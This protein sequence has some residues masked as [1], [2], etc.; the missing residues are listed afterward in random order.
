MTTHS[1]SSANPTTLREG[2]GGFVS[3]RLLRLCSVLLFLGLFLGTVFAGLR[4]FSPEPFEEAPPANHAYALDTMQAAVDWRRVKAIQDDLVGLG[5]RF[6]GQPGVYAAEDYI[7]Q[8]FLKAGVEVYEQENWTVVP[9][10]QFREIYVADEDTQGL[11]LPLTNVEIYPFMPNHLQPVTTPDEGVVGELV[12]LTQDALRTRTSFDDCIGLIDTSEG[13]LPEEYAFDWT[14]YAQLGLKAL[15]VSHPQGLS[16]VPWHHVANENEGMVSG[17]PVNFVRVAAD[18]G[19]FDQVGRRV[20]LRVRVRFEEVPNTTLVGVLRARDSS[21]QRPNSNAVILLSSYDACSILPDRA[22]GVSQALWPATQLALLEGLAPYRTGLSRD[23]IFIA[24]GAQV[25]ARDGENNLLRLLDENIVKKERNPLKKLLG[26]GQDQ[27][28]ELQEQTHRSG[29]QARLEPW[30]KRY[31]ANAAL[32]A[33]IDEILAAFEAEPFLREAEHTLRILDDLG[34][35]TRKYVEDQVGYTLDTVVFTLT[36]SKLQAKLAFLQSGNPDPSGEPFLAYLR[37]KSECDRMVAVARYS[38]PSLL[39]GRPRTEELL[40]RYALREKCRDRFLELRAHHAKKMRQR[41]KDIKLI[42]ALNPYKR[43]IVF[44][45]CLMPAFRPER[46]DEVLSFSNG[47]WAVNAQMRSMIS[48]MAS[49]R[50]RARE[51]PGHDQI[52]TELAI[53][54]LAKLHH[55][56]V[57]LNTRPLPERSANMWTQ[58]GYLM[59]KLLSFGRSD[60]YLHFADPVDQPYM[61]DV[62]SLKHSLAV[63]GETVLSLAHGNGRFAP[64]QVGWMKKQFGGRVL[65]SGIGQSMAPNYPLKGAVLGSRPYFGWEYSWPGFYDQLLIMSDVYGRYEIVNC[66]TDFWVDHYIWANGY[67]PVAAWHGED[68]RIAWM[69]DEGE[70]GQRLYKSVNLNWFKGDVEDITLVAFR[71]APVAFLDMTNPQT[72]QDYTGL[73]LL[74][75]DGLSTLRKQCV[76]KSSGVYA[77]YIEPDT[78]FYVT[79][80]SGSVD[81]ELAKVT[82]AFML[83]PPPS[84]VVGQATEARQ[85]IDGEGYLAAEHP[86]M[87][88]MSQEVARSLAHLN[89][90]RLDLQNRHGMA[91]AQTNDYE[92]KSL[93]LLAASEEPAQPNHQATRRAR[94]AAVYGTLN[95]PV[96]RESIVE[97]LIG[98]LWYL[99]L[100]V[101]FVY[102]L[103][104]LLFCFSDIR[105]QIA[106][107]AILFPLVFVLLR[108]MHPAFEMVRSSLMILLGFIIILIAG[109]M[110]VLFFGKFKENLEDLRKKRGRVDAAEVNKFGVMGSAFM[111]GLNNMHRRKMRTWLT[112][113]TLTLI[114]FAMICFTSAN[115][116][117]AE[118]AIAI[119]KAPYQGILIKRKN[120][121]KF[122]EAELFALRTRYADRHRVCLRQMHLGVQNWEGQARPQSGTRDGVRERRP[123]PRALVQFHPAFQSTP[124]RSSIRSSSSRAPL[125]SPRRRRKPPK[126]VVPS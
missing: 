83:G 1:T 96:L 24:F 58:F 10:T 75:R 70:D 45:T 95:H 28:S 23:V 105:K 11:G 88:N 31:D 92:E 65:A 30:R 56:D 66:A 97:A 13:M 18:E 39:D 21:P 51:V 90:K 50:Q 113:A 35:E 104:K 80:E 109:G 112:C 41:D 9:Q 20:R 16:R 6:M 40:E 107:Q 98:I 122:S 8:A 68:G 2:K 7:R 60:S 81:N 43:L 86:I 12:V 59:F 67:S 103:E 121:R 14:R 61:H 42:E 19:I 125:G 124:I 84:G 94:N 27:H 4:V 5:S 72:M 29:Q 74:N 17:V 123:A 120:T 32:L 53:P 91:D 49:A 55:N 33:R 54:A 3:S 126:R 37:A 22:P 87:R 119:G 89:G 102:F 93:T 73:R 106:V 110:S 71:A 100:L 26:I 62:E 64:I 57:A 115:S 76:F 15:I 44:D 116:D 48:M 118:E 25:M 38:I 77:Y 85:E 99:A 117:I 69:K 46:R 36:E 78:Y 114:T 79:L 34:K 108:L 111:L 63:V 47:H 82:R 52:E 101:P